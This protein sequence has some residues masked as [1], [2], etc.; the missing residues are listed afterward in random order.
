MKFNKIVI[1]ISVLFV[2]LF[3]IVNES[4]RVSNTE[5]IAKFKY[6]QKKLIDEILKIHN[7]HEH[8]PY[9]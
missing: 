2:M 9:Q 4:E 3:M 1:I 8:I 7:N 5:N 6:R